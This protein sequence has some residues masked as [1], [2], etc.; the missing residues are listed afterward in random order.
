MTK[1]KLNQELELKRSES[2]PS[3]D[4]ALTDAEADYLIQR[5]HWIVRPSINLYEFAREFGR[6]LCFEASPDA[7]AIVRAFFKPEVKER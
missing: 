6:G 3:V 2:A 7:R 4:A 1:R 5:L